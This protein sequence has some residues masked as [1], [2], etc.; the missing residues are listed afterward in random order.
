MEKTAL[1]TDRV[2]LKYRNELIE[3]TYLFFGLN[4]IIIGLIN[5]FSLLL[6]GGIF[7]LLIKQR[8][9]YWFE[10][11]IEFNDEI[12]YLRFKNKQGF[13]IKFKHI[14]SVDFKTNFFVIKNSKGDNV[15]F[16]TKNILVGD[17]EKIKQIFN[18]TL[19]IKK[20]EGSVFYKST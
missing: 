18:Q 11:Y 8:R 12:V 16:N 13:K 15:I 5:I 17:L 6:L 2:I 19:F 20:E 9:K 14:H 10:D 1:K 3:A 7:I 4:F